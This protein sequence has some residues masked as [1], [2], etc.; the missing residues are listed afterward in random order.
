MIEQLRQLL[1]LTLAGGCVVVVLSAFLCGC[2]SRKSDDADEVLRKQVVEYLIQAEQEARKASDEKHELT[3]TSPKEDALY[4]VFYGYVWLDV[5]KARAIAD[6]LSEDGQAMV[7]SHVAIRFA[8]QGNVDRAIAEAKAIKQKERS[9]DALGSVASI[10]ARED[11]IATALEIA[12]M[13]P[14]T[15]FGETYGEIAKAQ[16]L[17][18]DIDGAEKTLKKVFDTDLQESLPRLIAAAKLVAMGGDLRK[19]ADHAKMDVDEMS[20][21]LLA[22]LRKRASQG[23]LEEARRTLS[24]VS[25]WTDRA[26]GLIAIADAQ[27]RKDDK[28]ACFKT[29]SH[30]RPETREPRE[31]G[32]RDEPEA[33]NL[34]IELVSICIGKARVL[35]DAGD[36]D[37]AFDTLK[38]AQRVA[39]RDARSGMG[40]AEASGPMIAE[41][42]IRA[43]RLDEAMK[44]AT[45]KN[46]KFEPRYVTMFAPCMQRGEIEK[47]KELMGPDTTPAVRS[48][49]Y[50]VAAMAIMEKIGVMKTSTRK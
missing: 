49:F 2:D 14:V 18:G 28:A 25:H 42:M 1:G 35:L 11:R 4:L 22:I 27:L 47:A 26:D 23:D 15:H 10:F 9:E 36:L 34:A 31:K 3:K 24:A 45:G 33:D 48:K 16:V 21:S 46:G 41:L 8:H 30:I 39:A 32:Q 37:G 43:G 12:N 19:A 6:Q 29:L 44:M 38:I 40:F 17:S 7:E 50:S 20:K 13:L 5:D